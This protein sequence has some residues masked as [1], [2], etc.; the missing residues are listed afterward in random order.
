MYIWYSNGLY[1]S[2]QYVNANSSITIDGRAVATT[3]TT[4][5]DMV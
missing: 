2:L 1:I 3:V 5:T 4:A